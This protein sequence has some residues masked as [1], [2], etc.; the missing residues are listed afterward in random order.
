MSSGR[1]ETLV[2]EVLGV[3]DTLPDRPLIETLKTQGVTLQAHVSTQ[4]TGPALVP[5]MTCE[6]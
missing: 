2:I 4:L 3:K 5:V 6:S 1:P